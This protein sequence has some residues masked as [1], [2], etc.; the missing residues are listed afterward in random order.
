MANPH[1]IRFEQLRLA[2]VIGLAEYASHP[3][4]TKFQYGRHRLKL[5]YYYLIACGT[6]QDLR[7]LVQ[8]I[9]GSTGTDMRSFIVRSVLNSGYFDPED[10]MKIRRKH[11]SLKSENDYRD[12]VVLQKLLGTVDHSQ[13]EVV[14][15]LLR[16]LNNPT[17]DDLANAKHIDFQTLFQAE[18][19]EAQPVD[20]EKVVQKIRKAVLLYLRRRG[21]GAVT[22]RSK[23]TWERLEERSD[24]VVIKKRGFFSSDRG[25]GQ[26]LLR[27]EKLLLVCDALLERHDIDLKEAYAVVDA[28]INSEAQKLQ[29]YV[30]QYVQLSGELEQ[31]KLADK[32]ECA[33]LVITAGNWRLHEAMESYLT[34]QYD[35]LLASE[36]RREL[37]N[38]E[39]S[40]DWD[41]LGISTR[42]TP[43]SSAA[44]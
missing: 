39:K 26:S 6:E 31:V 2:L 29:D 11:K 8:A 15:D 21:F 23:E 30:V 27:A 28:I 17:K 34:G 9:I 22:S 43:D 37:D 38:D 14:M 4:K 40:L 12:Y 19:P 41:K 35:R 25:S 1:N 13:I 33:A 5:A 3:I 44:A 32:M 20:A 42:S 24:V 18:L 16:H 36:L 7:V 10:V